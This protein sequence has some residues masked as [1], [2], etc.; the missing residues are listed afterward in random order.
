MW[1]F[2][3]SKWKIPILSSK[4]AIFWKIFRNFSIWLQITN[5]FPESKI[6]FLISYSTSLQL[7]KNTKTTKYIKMQKGTIIMLRRWPPSLGL[8]NVT[9][10]VYSAYDWGLTNNYDSTMPTDSVTNAIIAK[11]VFPSTVSETLCVTY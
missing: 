2:L 6:L 9:G 8:Q 10:Y 11:P 3:R 4:M 5:L 1:R 7:A